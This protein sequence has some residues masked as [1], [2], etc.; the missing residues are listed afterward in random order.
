MCRRGICP[1]EGSCRFT[2]HCRS[3]AAAAPEQGRYPME[4]ERRVF[5]TRPI[6][7]PALRRLAQAARVELWDDD[8]PPAHD[9]LLRRL[10]RADA[11]LS[12]VSDRFD[13]ATIAVLPQLAAISNLAVGVDNIDLAAATR[14]GIPVGHTPGV[15]TETTADLA[16]A[17][18][19]AA[20]RRVVE[21]DQFVRAGRW[22]TWTP[23]LMLGRHLWGATLGIIGW[24]AIGQA[25][26]R[27][28]GGFGMR[29]LYVSRRA[30]APAPA[31]PAGAE[32][33]ALAQ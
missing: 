11:V 14:A 6:A 25:V 19:M 9:E 10:A 29:I 31:N 21:A 27:R 3:R 18:M 28:A 8:L 23:R 17:L 22:R 24:R 33:V 2:C 7:P 20:A 4:H 5:V 13:A 16:F 12:M 30:P 32:C 26:A 15:L 1:S